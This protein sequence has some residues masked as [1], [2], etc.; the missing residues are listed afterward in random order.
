MMK[1]LKRIYCKLFGCDSPGY[2]PQ[3][4]RCGEWYYDGFIQPQESRLFPIKM[5]LIWILTLHRHVV[6]RCAQCGK[7]MWF[8]KDRYV[9]LC[10]KEC[11]S[12]WI[13]F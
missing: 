3:C 2:E 8:P 5:A 13:P 10:S 6:T 11:D 9:S 1:R 4:C 12:N 7:L